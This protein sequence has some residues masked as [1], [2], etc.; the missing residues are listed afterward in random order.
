[1][2]SSAVDR[3]GRLKL[4]EVYN[5]VV[6]YWRSHGEA[7]LDAF[8]HEELTRAANDVRRMAGRLNKLA[9]LE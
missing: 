4:D 9:S 7:G 1:M 3:L 8:I 5:R 2:Y 6:L